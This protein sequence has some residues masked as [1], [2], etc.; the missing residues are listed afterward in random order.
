MLTLANG[1]IVEHERVLD[2]RHGIV[3]RNWQQRLR[4]GHT[5]RVRTARF[6]SLADRQLLA[7]RAEA[8]PGGLRRALVG[9]ARSA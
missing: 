5:L 2:M 6:A 3:F 1:E 7:M 4:S 8:T 9:Q